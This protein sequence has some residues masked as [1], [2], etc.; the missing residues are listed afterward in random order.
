M[1]KRTY[2]II[3]KNESG[4]EVAQNVGGAGNG[5]KSG[6]GKSSAEKALKTV[7]SWQTAKS[8]VSPIIAYNVG[9]VQLRTG[10][11]EAQQQMNF[12]YN[13]A[14]R[15]LNVA[16]SI[17]GGYLAGNAVGA[18]IGLAVGVTHQLMDIGLNQQRLNLQA[19]IENVSRDITAQ[20]ATFSGSRYQTLT[21]E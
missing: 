7:F 1:S 15:A 13:M 17:V 10:S 6:G 9:T 14:G 19:D 5:K 20:R 16:E 4:G 18:V 3:I 8:F 2:E 21:Q 11:T 12:V